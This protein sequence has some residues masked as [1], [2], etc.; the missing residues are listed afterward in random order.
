MHDLKNQH[1]GSV[2]KNFKCNEIGPQKKCWGSG[3]VMGKEKLSLPSHFIKE[4]SEGE[5]ARRS[6]QP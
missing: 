4:G 6:T 3:K 5:L 1:T 2:F